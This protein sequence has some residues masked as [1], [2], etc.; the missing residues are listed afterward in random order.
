MNPE[1]IPNQ[2]TDEQRRCMRFAGQKFVA[3]YFGYTYE[4]KADDVIYAR[5]GD[6]R[7]YLIAA[8]VRRISGKRGWLRS[9]QIFHAEHLPSIA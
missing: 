2:W 4:W 6:L 1:T 9:P 5:G 8:P 3:Y 7:P